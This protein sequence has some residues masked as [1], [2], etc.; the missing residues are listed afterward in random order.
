M[1]LS[2]HVTTARGVLLKLA[3]KQT[4]EINSLRVEL[5]IVETPADCI[6]FVLCARTWLQMY[7]GAEK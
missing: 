5:K 7:R 3:E 2:V 1:P 4:A 6:T